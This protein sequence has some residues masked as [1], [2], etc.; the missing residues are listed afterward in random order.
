M[1]LSHSEWVVLE[2]SDI[3]SLNKIITKIKFQRGLRLKTSVLCGPS[4]QFCLFHIS[5]HILSTN[6]DDVDYSHGFRGTSARSWSSISG[7]CYVP[8][9]V[10][11]SH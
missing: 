7:T 11:Q 3:F 4:L 5:R 6:D 1:Q 10:K 9:V 8:R 2:M